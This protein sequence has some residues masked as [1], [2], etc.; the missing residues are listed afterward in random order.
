[1]EYEFNNAPQSNFYPDGSMLMLSVKSQA[2]H[3]IMLRNP[4]V[5]TALV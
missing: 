2:V 5:K 3:Q 1:L 4:Q